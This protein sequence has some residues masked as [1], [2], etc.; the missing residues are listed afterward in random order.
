MIKGKSFKAMAKDIADGYVAV[1]PIFLKP[2]D[3]ET[4]KAL[5]QELQK[6]QTEIRTEKFPYL[7]TEAIRSRNA[8]LQRLYSASMIL[9]NFARERRIIII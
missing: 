4:L 2:L 5:N 8:R 1:N 6:A 3:A 7:D 9:R